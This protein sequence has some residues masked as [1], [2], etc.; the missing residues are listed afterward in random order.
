MIRGQVRVCVCVYIYIY[1][2]TRLPHSLTSVGQTLEVRA[3]SL[4]YVLKYVVDACLFF[5]L[6]ETRSRQNG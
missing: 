4:G 6:V 3:I 5:K 1:T 2:P